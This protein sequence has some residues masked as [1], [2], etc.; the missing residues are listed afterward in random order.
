MITM[1]T[2]RVSIFGNNASI[3]AYSGTNELI[4]NDVVRSVRALFDNYDYHVSSETCYQKDNTEVYT[5]TNFF[6]ED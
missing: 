6:L 2:Y 5:N 4:Y 1:A 3:C